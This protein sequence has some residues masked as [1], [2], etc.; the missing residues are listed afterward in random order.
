MDKV[1]QN[2]VLLI[3]G[4]T[5]QLKDYPLCYPS[6]LSAVTANP[7]CRPLYSPFEF[8]DLPASIRVLNPVPCSACQTIQLLLHPPPLHLR[9]LHRSASLRP[10]HPDLPPA[11]NEPHAYRLYCGRLAL[12]RQAGQSLRGLQ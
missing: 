5:L 7:L 9:S 4:T 11:L 3:L 12:P 10:R 8:P 2:N 6:C 1:K